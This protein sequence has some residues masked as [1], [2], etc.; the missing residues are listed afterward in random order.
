MFDRVDIGCGSC[1][2]RDVTVGHDSLIG[3]NAVVVTSIP[4][5]ATAVGVPA[6]VIKQSSLDPCP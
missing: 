2:L 1:V 3:A 6:H 4:P 5:C